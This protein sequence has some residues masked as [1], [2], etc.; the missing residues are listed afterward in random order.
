MFWENRVADL[1]L[2]F[3]LLQTAKYHELTWCL[4][5]W[6]F[7]SKLR[8][9]LDCILRSNVF[10]VKIV[11]LYIFSFSEN[12]HFP[13]YAWVLSDASHLQRKRTHTGR[14]KVHCPFLINEPNRVLRNICNKMRFRNNKYLFFIQYL[15]WFSTVF[16]YG[17]CFSFFF[18]VEIMWVE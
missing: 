3:E 13:T 11:F 10:F 12:F 7:V 9:I 16:E 5:I 18:H 15:L 8:H 17:D 6:S 1:F 2:G 4:V 14:F